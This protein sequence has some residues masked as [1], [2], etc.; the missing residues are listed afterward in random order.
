MKILS[1]SVLSLLIITQV[2]SALNINFNDVTSGG[3]SAQALQGF[4]DAATLW[5][6]ELS[7]NVTVN[8]DIQF[9][10]LGAGIIGSAGSQTAGF[11]YSAVKTAL[12]S[13]AKTANDATA[14]SNLPSGSALT[15]RTQNSS[16]TIITDNDGGS[17]NSVL[18][19]NRANAKAIGLISGTDTAQDANISFNSDFT[20]D[21]D[22]S[23]G[24]AAGAFDFVGIA[25]HEIGHS[26]GFR[27]GVD[28][29][30]A[31]H[32]NGASAPFDLSSF[33]VFSVWDLFRYSADS[34]ALGS[35]ILDLATGGSP[36]FSIN[37]GTIALANYST[38]SANGDGQQASH[39]KDSLGIGLLDPTASLAE[40]LSVSANDLLAFDVM[41]WDSAS[42]IPEPAETA[43]MLGFAMILGRIGF[44]KFK[45]S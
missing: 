38:G 27:S 7:D 33:R 22:A 14:V 37:G 39:W 25:A 3:M 18:D 5:E 28:V 26:L 1:V 31:V 34:V 40:N 9:T 30:D 13:D 2:T 42:A 44:K 23:N 12:T 36:Y 20:F 6:N 32:T 24:I 8:V 11:S 41:G 15:F 43:F 10:V 21:F 4:N 45:S 29:V 35:E 19:V 16:G 17:N